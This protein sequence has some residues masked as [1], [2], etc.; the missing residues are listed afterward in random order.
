MEKNTRIQLTLVIYLLFVALL[1]VLKPKHIYN[2]D[3]TLRTFG[4]K[5]ENTLFPL[6]FLIFFG[7]F[8]SY[9]LTHIILFLFSKKI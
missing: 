5:K 4:T 9:Y 2:K 7:A 3:G 6:W 1:I 8:G